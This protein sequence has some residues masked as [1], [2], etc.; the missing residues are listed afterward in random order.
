M[1]ETRKVFM[2]LLFRL[3]L[4]AVLGLLCTFA[5][6]F[7]WKILSPF[8]IALCLAAML[9]PFVRF[10]T[11]K[12]RFKRSLAAFIAVF[13]VCA[14]ALLILYWFLSFVVTQ[15]LSALQNA[16]QLIQSLQMTLKAL[17][18]KLTGALETTKSM[19]EW[20]SAS[21]NKAYAWLTSWATNTAGS[22]ISGTLDFALGLPGALIYAN[23]LLLSL[24]F[25]TQRFETLR[26]YFPG[27]NPE[28]LSGKLRASAGVGLVGYIR[29]QAIY[30]LFVLG[31]S[32]AY[33][34]IWGFPYAVLIALAAALL[35]F[36]PLFGNGTLYIP[37][38][39]VCFILGDHRTAFI[40]L[41][42][43]AFLYLTRKFTEPRLMS[44]KMG[45]S[46]LISLLSMY[47]GMKA[48]GVLGLT[49][50]PVVAVVIV[51]AWR[52]GLF[53]PLLSDIRFACETL[54]TRLAPAKND[55]DKGPAATKD[56]TPSNKAPSDP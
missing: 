7:L 49:F 50:G 5:L 15:V 54:K 55:A 39:I 56:G 37:W 19:P 14:A 47:V 41:G 12:L 20:L 11:N 40:V 21:L 26:K 27:A 4:L 16:P 44:D 38:I 46:P 34:Q 31:V 10:A 29:V 48:G 17:E 53:G 3:A 18:D 6:P 52:G 36:L 35:E 30:T 33:L 28:T 13:F 8:V 22:L 51:S 1:T 25:M 2:R 9:Q 32:W 45:L 43:H 24:F 42:V 23:F